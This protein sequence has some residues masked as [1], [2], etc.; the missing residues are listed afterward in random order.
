MTY[1]HT[2]SVFIFYFYFNFNS[3]IVFSLIGLVTS[4]PSIIALLFPVEVCQLSF[5]LFL[6]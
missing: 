4:L 2:Y 1:N 3:H 5:I 6:N